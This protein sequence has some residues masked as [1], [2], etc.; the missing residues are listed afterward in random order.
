[1]VSSAVGRRV[2]RLRKA[3]DLSQPELA[4]RAHMHRTHL[5]K[6]ELGISD[7]TASTIVKLARALR[8]TPGRLFEDAPGAGRRHRKR[9]RKP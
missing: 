4:A 1:M 9:R 6:I 5:A 2:R 8:V 3:L 7:P